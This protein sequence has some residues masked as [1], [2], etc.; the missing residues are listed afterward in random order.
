MTA[1]ALPPGQRARED[2]PRF[3]LWP[4][5]DRVPTVDHPVA[6]A[7]SGDVMA[8]VTIADPL[9][10]LPRTELVADFHCVTTWTHRAVRWSGVSFA[11]FHAERIVAH[12]REGCAPPNLVV[13]RGGDGYRTTLPLEDLLAPDVLLAD[14]LNGAPLPVRHGAPLRLVAPAHYGYKQVKHLSRL[15]FW[16]DTPVLRARGFEFVDH[17]RARVAYEERGRA[18]PGWLL[19]WLYRPFIPATVRRFARSVE[20]DGRMARP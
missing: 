4:Y 11:T 20:R 9:A 8:S 15:E 18:A 5:A 13:L 19:R 2:F 12:Q 7:V 14:Q 10:G 6:L 17:P 3:G 1:A 16:A